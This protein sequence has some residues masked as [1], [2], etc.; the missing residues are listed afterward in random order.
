[1]GGGGGGWETRVTQGKPPRADNSFTLQFSKS[2]GTE[3][4]SHLSQRVGHVV[5]G[6]GVCL[7]WSIMV[8]RGK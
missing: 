8:G 5:P 7:L 3:E 4:P 6:V 1:M 2:C